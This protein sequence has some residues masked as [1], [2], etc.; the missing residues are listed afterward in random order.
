MRVFQEEIFGPVVSVA[1]FK[2]D[3]EALSIANDTLYGLGAGLWTRDGNRAYRMGR[4]IKAGR[5][6]VSL[7]AVIRPHHHSGKM[8]GAA[9]N[10]AAAGA[11]HCRCAD[12]RVKP[13]HDGKVWA[14]GYFH[15]RRGGAEKF[16]LHRRHCAV[17]ADRDDGRA[18]RGAC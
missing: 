11:L 3:D 6:W 4:G 13:A 15:G 7:P 8:A 9:T 2:D 16:L 12:G 18:R 1:R 17:L 10:S 5:V 14:F